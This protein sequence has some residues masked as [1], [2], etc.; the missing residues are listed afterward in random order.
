[1]I[2][3]LAEKL[4]PPTEPGK[5][6]KPGCGDLAFFVVI[7]LIGVI[8]GGI[9]AFSQNPIGYVILIGTLIG[10]FAYAFAFDNK[11]KREYEQALPGW[12]KAMKKWGKLYFCFRDG[13]VFNPETNDTCTPEDLTDYIYS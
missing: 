1:M 4:S 10:I 6:A 8:F 11:G 7:P 9:L 5:K 13:L 2:T 12:K 3:E